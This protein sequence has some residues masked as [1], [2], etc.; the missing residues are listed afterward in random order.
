MVPSP[1]RATER[2][3]SHEKQVLA[4][5][6][7]RRVDDRGA[8]GWRASPADS[9][10]ELFE[11]AKL[12]EQSGRQSA[13]VVAMYQE[14]ATKADR[15]LAAA[16]RLQIAMLKEREG[17]S[18]ARA[19]YAAIIR[20]YPDQRDV[21][22]KAQSKL[23]ARTAGRGGRSDVVARKVL[24][25]GWAAVVDISANGRTAIGWERAGYSSRN[26]VA[27]DMD[28]GKETL[29]V[30]GG[31][32][33]HSAHAA[34]F[35][36]CCAVSLTTGTT[37]TT[38]RVRLVGF[39]AIAL[40]AGA[41]PEILLSQ[42]DREMRPSGW[43]P[44]G[45]RLLVNVNRAGETGVS[46]NTRSEIGWVSLEDRL[47]TSLKTFE[48]WQ[49][50]FPERLSPDGRFVAYAAEPRVGVDLIITSTC[51]IRRACA[52]RRSSQQRAREKRP[53][54]RPMADTCSTRKGRR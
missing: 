32:A 38:E 27:R 36:P 37:W 46:L 33:R 42:A 39:C 41:N 29:V 22:S 50:H 45:K 24:E 28:T 16:A 40:E 18:E 9:Q 4:G 13:R 34:D 6:T 17:Q 10:R 21:V 11:R 48:P 15:A 51:S 52:R 43:S 31:P 1:M 19:L 26:L 14:V 47:Y 30:A 44:D 25:G 53:Y 2:E 35:G 7:D 8:V 5:G 49:N 23:A 3:A 20:D 12:L 54:G